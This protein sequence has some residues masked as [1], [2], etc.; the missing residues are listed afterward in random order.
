MAATVAGCGTITPSPTDLQTAS[1]GEPPSEETELAL[2]KEQV[3]PKLKDPYSA[4]YECAPARQGWANVMGH[5]SYGWIVACTVNAKNSFGAYN[6]AREHDFLWRDGQVVVN[7][8][9]TLAR[10]ALSQP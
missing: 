3:G 1:Y 6:G 5:L 9:T 10:F 2:I 7:G 4:M 8:E